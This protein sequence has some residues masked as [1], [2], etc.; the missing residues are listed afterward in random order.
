MEQRLQREVVVEEEEA[1]MTTA[2]RLAE[3]VT[4]IDKVEVPE[5][6]A[7]CLLG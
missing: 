1:G 4:A 3:R 6:S 2:C 7:I 5:G